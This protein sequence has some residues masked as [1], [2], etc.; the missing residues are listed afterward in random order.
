MTIVI[1]RFQCYLVLAT[2]HGNTNWD[3]IWCIVF[4]TQNCAV[5]IDLLFA[6][7]KLF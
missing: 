6:V 3:I 7:L 2:S 5:R 1:L 4:K